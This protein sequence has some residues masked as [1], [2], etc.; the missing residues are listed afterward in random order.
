[1]NWIEMLI[2]AIAIIIIIVFVKLYI[3]MIIDDLSN[4]Y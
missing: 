3:E 1:M 2:L 4:K